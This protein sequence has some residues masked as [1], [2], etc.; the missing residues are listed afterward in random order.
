MSKALSH[1]AENAPHAGFYIP[2]EAAGAVQ[3]IA[4]AGAAVH[5]LHV[6]GISDADGTLQRDDS[7]AGI[8]RLLP[9]FV[10]VDRKACVAWF[11]CGHHGSEND[12]FTGIGSEYRGR[13]V[14]VYTAAEHL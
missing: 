2:S 10:V 4:G 3:V 12:T 6:K 7:G 13:R 11:I 9:P 1:N 8:V 14:T 5:Q